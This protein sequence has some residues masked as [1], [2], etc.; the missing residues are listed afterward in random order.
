MY[1]LFLKRILDIVCSALGLVIL[2][3][4]FIVLTPVVAIAMRGNPFF[5][6]KR[7]GKHGKVF[8]LIKFRTMN[9]KKDSYGI[10]LP[11]EL[12][13]TKFGK[14]MRALSVDELPELIN[15]LFGKMSIVGPR[16]L[17]ERYLPLYNEFQARRHEV[18]PGL[19]GLAQV[20]GRNAISW[21]QKFEKDVY[22]VDH[23]SLLLDIKI[24]FLTIKKVF[25]REGISQNGQATMEY[26]TGNDSPRA[27]EEINGDQNADGLCE[28]A[29]VAV[30]TVDS[31]VLSGD[32]INA[33][34]YT[35][36]STAENRGNSDCLIKEDNERN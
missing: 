24:F 20:S 32:K 36:E 31:P 34:E 26:F 9:N 30:N 10:L 27:T 23:C 4:L 5:I 11:D 7:P 21:E 29:T 16:P 35:V 17:L 2:S 22:Y 8:R 14:I 25:I 13:I 12:R 6:Q 3:P 15:I 1:K 18:R 33:D 28:D 19:T